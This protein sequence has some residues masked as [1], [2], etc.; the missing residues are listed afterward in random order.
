MVDKKEYGRKRANENMILAID[1]YSHGTNK[2]AI[3]GCNAPIE[4]LTLEHE[5]FDRITL[6]RQ[7]GIYDYTGGT[8][9]ARVLRLRGF[10]DV[11]TTVKCM[12]HNA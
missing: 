2:C 1:H 12:M 8:N 9:L 7:L 5:N 11:G 6:N 4:S 10:P 3:I